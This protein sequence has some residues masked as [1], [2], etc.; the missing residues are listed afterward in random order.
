MNNEELNSVWQL[1]IKVNQNQIAT[2]TNGDLDNHIRS[3]RID[4]ALM[5]LTFMYNHMCKKYMLKT[6]PD[7]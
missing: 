3:E 4:W 7:T 2:K 1:F 5:G 6:N